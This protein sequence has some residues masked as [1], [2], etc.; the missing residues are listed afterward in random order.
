MS[1]FIE[2]KDYK[3]YSNDYFCIEI[4]GDKRYKCRLC[5]EE[6]NDNKHHFTKYHKGF[7]KEL[8]KCSQSFQ[9]NMFNILDYLEGKPA[10]KQQTNNQQNSGENV[11]IQETNNN[12]FNKFLTY[13]RK[14]IGYLC[15]KHNIS[16]ANSTVFA[17]FLSET[18]KMMK[19]YNLGECNI[20]SNLSKKLDHLDEHTVSN[21]VKQ[22]GEVLKQQTFQKIANSNGIAIQLD[23]ST[24]RSKK[25]QT[26]VHAR[27][28][29]NES[30]FKD[31]DDY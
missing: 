5:C 2:N 26:I 20:L 27:I 24:D 29:N 4:N 1:L 10:R 30:D 17:S 18:T 14:Y 6:F 7:G 15:A 16:Y 25:S 19:N 28:E 11:P 22:L 12:E 9:E 13:M 21:S 3:Y 31:F 23:E 8:K